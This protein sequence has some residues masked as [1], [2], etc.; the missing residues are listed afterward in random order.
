VLFNIF[1]KKPLKAL[2]CRF[3]AVRVSIGREGGP[4]IKL[5]LTDKVSKESKVVEKLATE[6]EL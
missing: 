5:A 1:L 3:F 4:S 2:D 6:S